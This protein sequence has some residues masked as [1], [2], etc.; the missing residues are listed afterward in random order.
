MRG[1]VLKLGMTMFLTLI[2]TIYNSN[3]ALSKKN[4]PDV[5]PAIK[6]VKVNFDDENIIIVGEGFGGEGGIIVNL[7]TLGSL[8]IISREPEIL[9]VGFPFNGLL[10]GSYLLTVLTDKAIATHDMTTGAVGEFV[11][12]QKDKRF[13]FSLT[14][15]LRGESWVVFRQI[16]L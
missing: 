16:R 1:T 12:N 15:D 2:F 10:P 14:N 5:D 4:I 7:G 3:R 11:L 6:E 8:P 13:H 9:I